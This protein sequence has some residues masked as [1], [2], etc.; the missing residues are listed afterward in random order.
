MFSKFAFAVYL[1]L[2]SS[3][4]FLLSKYPGH[5]GDMPFYIVCA[6]Q[7]GQGS[8][9]EAVDEA[10]VYLKKELP[11]NEFTEH[12][13]RITKV[14][15]TYFDFYRIKPLYI[16]MVMLFHAIG[17]SFTFSTVLPSLLFYFLTGITIWRF[18][19]Q[20]MDPAK[21]FLVS[22]MTIFP[23]YVLARLSSPDA[24][25][26][27]F[28]LNALLFMYTGRNRILWFCLLLLAI[29][30]RLD[31]IVGVLIL[32]VALFKWP[33]EKYAGKLQIKEFSFFMLIAIVVAILINVIFTEHF[34]GIND[35]FSERTK[36][37]YLT[38]VKWYILTLPGSFLLTLLILFIFTR[39]DREF[40]WTNKVNYLI[41]VILT[42]VFV[43][44]L[45][46]PFYEERFFAPY[47]I[48]GML[49]ISFQFSSVMVI[50]KEKNKNE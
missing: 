4:T 1:L 14:S 46:Y 20:C 22:V 42:V 34:L 27:F 39:R 28:I 19:I 2:L 36:T 31:N 9:D 3:F 15:T 35:P 25:S 38:D 24:M 29:C 23:F 37:E 32:L 43:R 50:E 16:L 48:F 30:T 21:S 40:R 41:Y 11:S 12:S 10:V 26:C 33:D 18:S 47:I 5:N 44:F 6:I 13:G 7:F 17:F 49:I 45:L 8:M